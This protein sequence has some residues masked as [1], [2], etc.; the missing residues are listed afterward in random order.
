MKL[1]L[2]A[3]ALASLAIPQSAVACGGPRN[4]ALIHSGLPNPLPKDTF[5]A[6]VEIETSDQWKLYTSG[7]EARVTRPIAGAYRGERIILRLPEENSC[8]SP[9]ANGRSGLLV[10]IPR[11]REGDAWVLWPALVSQYDGYRLRDGF[12]FGKSPRR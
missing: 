8:D 1:A 11:S 9:F 2:P 10:A 6:E 3:L 12:Q 7:L 5:I 4:F